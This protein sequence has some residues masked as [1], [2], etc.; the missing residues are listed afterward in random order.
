MPVASSSTEFARRRIAIVSRCSRTLFLF[1]RSLALELLCRGADVDTYGAE[2]EGFGARLAECGIRFSPLK[3]ALRG[4]NPARD[5]TYLARLWR[6][7]LIRRPDLVHCFTIKPAIFGNLAAA[8]ARVPVRV[9]TIT[10][11]GYLFTTAPKV[12]RWFGESLYR[13]S[14]R[15]AHRVYFQNRDD[16]SLFASR[17][18]CRPD[19]CR[20]VQG[21]GVDIEQFQPV[22]FPHEGRP[23]SVHFVMVARLLK[24]KGVY[25]Y[26]E[27][28]R[29][30]GRR[31]PDAQFTL[32]GGLD[33]ANPSSLKAE[34]V[35]DM[36][37]TS[38]VN[39]VG[40]VSDVRPFLCAA[41]VFVLPS[42]RE[43]LPRAALEA[44]AMGRPVVATDVPG[45][46][47]VVTDGVT[48]FLVPL[49]DVPALAKAMAKFVV[50][51]SLISRFGDAGRRIVVEQFSEQAVIRQTIEAYE[52]L[53]SKVR[54]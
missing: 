43:G 3:L 11:L 37:A 49:Q 44:A 29:L 9:V 36:R 41:D 7:F 45:C 31:F 26:V 12:L 22:S 16:M 51:T 4:L 17:G 10:G 40:D 2:L 20:L 1:R 27:A 24:E 33:A 39:F 50:D 54:A 48:G 8:A 38:R 53:L 15:F 42:Y 21:S 30:V 19:Q 32:V 34:D 46:R 47:E 23:G 28:A 14:L 6:V 35:R 18:I 5:L 52:E 13:V 25:E